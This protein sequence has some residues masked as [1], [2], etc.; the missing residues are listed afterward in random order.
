[1]KQI[2]E[3]ELKLQFSENTTSNKEKIAKPVFEEYVQKTSK[4]IKRPYFQTFKMV[5]DW[6][7]HKLIRR[8]NECMEYQG[9]M[10][11]DVLWWWKRKQDK[12]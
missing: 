1:M 5:E 6:Q 3:L 7:E 12:S 10:P 9:K 11:R 2:G 4:L 8:Y